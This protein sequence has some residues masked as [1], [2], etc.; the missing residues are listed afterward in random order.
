MRIRREEMGAP[1]SDAS[2]PPRLW[3]VAAWSNRDSKRAD[4][5]MCIRVWEHGHMEH[6]CSHVPRSAT[7]CRDQVAKWPDPSLQELHVRRLVLFNFLQNKLGRIA[8]RPDQTV[9]TPR[10]INPRATVGSWTG[11]GSAQRVLFEQLLC[12]KPIYHGKHL[13][14]VPSDVSQSGARAER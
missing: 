14:V 9:G 8:A 2:R 5:H 11:A 1:G 13:L 10:S 3:Q 6:A 4:R 7:T 12:Y